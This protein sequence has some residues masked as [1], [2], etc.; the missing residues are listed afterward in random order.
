MATEEGVNQEGAGA[1]EAKEG[2]SGEEQ[3]VVANAA[4]GLRRALRAGQWTG[5]VEVFGLG[6]NS[7]SQ[8]AGMQA[9]LEMCSRDNGSQSLNNSLKMSRK[10]GLECEEDVG[11]T[12]M[13]SFFL[14]LL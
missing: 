3:A 10:M 1:L 14:S 6:K 2:A 8:V 9:S 4:A 13:C 5:N 12:M 7:V 11:A